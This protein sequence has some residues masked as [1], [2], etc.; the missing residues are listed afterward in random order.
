[1]RRIAIINQKG[2]VGKTTTAVNLG[3]ALARAGRRV[4]V[5]D[6][7]PQANA[8]LHLGAELGPEEASIYSVLCGGVPFEQALRGTSIPGLSLLPS[9]I[10]LSGAELELASAI[11]RETVLRDAI[12]DWMAAAGGPPTDY[13]LFDCPPSLGLLSV[14][15]LSAAEEVIVVL[16]TE[17]FALQGLSKLIEIIQLLRRRLN[18]DLRLSGVLPCLYD[19]RLR[20]AREVLGEIRRYF[21]EQVFKTPIRSNVKLAEAPSHGQTIFEYDPSSSGARDYAALAQELLDLEGGEPSPKAAEPAPQEV[22]QLERK[23]SGLS[24]QR[25][26]QPRPNPSPPDP[27][28]SSTPSPERVE[29]DLLP[30]APSEATEE[31]DPSVAGFVI[32]RPQAQAAP[33]PTEEEAPEPAQHPSS[34]SHSDEGEAITRGSSPEGVLSGNYAALPEGN[35]VAGAI[36]L[37]EI[38]VSQEPET[39]P[40]AEP[41]GGPFL[42]DPPGPETLPTEPAPAPRPTAEEPPLPEPEADLEPSPEPK[43]PPKHLFIG[44][45]GAYLRSHLGPWTGRDSI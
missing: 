33:A 36:T 21:G 37:P 1:M 17:F 43:S 40:P 2:G 34:P 39:A 4:V 31:Q 29:D 38:V 23:L 5:V 12:A 28:E 18:P 16:Q 35:G 13:L 7:D 14:N 22:A 11:G 32:P 25:S 6:L 15:G 30:R 27:T 26:P 19:S 44:E 41:P 45:D 8:S 10:D 9:H 3:A 42:I 20:L 24:R